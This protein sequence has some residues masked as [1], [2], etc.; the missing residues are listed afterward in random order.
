MGLLMARKLKL[1]IGGL[2]EMI[3]QT[4][5]LD[6]GD[7][8]VFKVCHRPFKDLADAEWM[9]LILRLCLWMNLFI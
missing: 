2:I 8:F 6:L 1:R 5:D 9:L 4:S 3:Y 7:R